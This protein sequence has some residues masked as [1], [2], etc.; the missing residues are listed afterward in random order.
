MHIVK[1]N[2]LPSKRDFFFVII[3]K[4]ISGNNKMEEQE[5]ENIF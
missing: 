3:W 4:C 1:W 2:S 5:D